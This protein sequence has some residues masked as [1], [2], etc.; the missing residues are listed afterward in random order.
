M[1]IQHYAIAFLIIVLPFSI[2]CRSLMNEKIDALNDET[3]INNAIDTA[4]TDAIDTL[5]ELNDEF[6]AMYEGETLDVT[7]VIAKE[8]LDTF[9]KTMAV[10]FNLPFT[11]NN[12]LSEE[13]FSAYIPAV[14]VIA[15]D[16]FYVYSLEETAAGF[17]Y[18]L[19][20]KIPYAYEENGYIINFSLGNYIEL[21]ARNGVYYKGEFKENYIDDPVVV[22]EYEQELV[23][24]LGADTLNYLPQ[25]TEDMSLII[26][27]LEDAGNT[28]LPNFLTTRSSDPNSIPMLND[29]TTNDDYDNVSAFHKKR[30]EIIINLIMETLNEKMN[31]QNRYADM[32]GIT[33]DFFLPEIDDDDWMNSINDVSVM[34]FIQGIPIGQKSYYNNYALG[35]SRIIRSDFI[36]GTIMDSHK[37]YHKWNCPYLSAHIDSEGYP[38]ETSTFID[39][40]FL[41]NID[42]A[43]AGYY[44]CI[45]CK[46]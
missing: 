5:I 2:V 6:Y 33:Y 15:Y 25:L 42:A 32:M 28:D 29:Y 21:Y 40:L 27:A 31:N 39:N 26:Y 3:R 7:P 16:G 10:N 1:K 34:S 36:Y 41:N 9:F 35:A 8:A 45:E 43:K 18:V 12:K 23:P 37:V 4:T 22:N 19:S 30:R 14:L 24:I 44:P 20:P 17:E 13:Y 46:P 38:L 11:E